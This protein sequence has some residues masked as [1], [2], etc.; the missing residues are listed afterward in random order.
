[1]EIRSILLAAGASRR[2]GSDKLL[3]DLGG[4]P[5]LV[6]AALNLVAGGVPVLCVVRDAAGP[7]AGALGGIPGITISACPEAGLGMGRSL[8]WGVAAAHSA[9]AW[10][11]ALGDMPEVAPDTIRRLIRALRAQASIV[12]PEYA[13]VRGHPVGFARR[14]VSEL[15]ALQGDQGARGLLASHPE[16]LWRVRVRDP[17]VLRDLDHPKDLAPGS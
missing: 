12:A 17:G 1:M 7:V 16:H 11:V 14:W 6:R 15:L 5:M 2:F 8:A 3:A 9:D 13:G 4:E 10:L